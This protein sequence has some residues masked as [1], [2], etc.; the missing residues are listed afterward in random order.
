MDLNLE[1]EAHRVFTC[2]RNEI[3][4]TLSPHRLPCGDFFE[5]DELCGV[6]LIPADLR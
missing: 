4:R 5:A 6:V 2:A 1:S 3:S